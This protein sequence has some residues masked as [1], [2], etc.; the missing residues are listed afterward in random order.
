MLTRVDPGS[1]N[2]LYARLLTQGLSARSVAHVHG[3]V[4]K[5]LK[6]AVRWGRLA[7]NPADAADPPRAAGKHAAMV[8]WDATET[9]QFSRCHEEDRLYAAWLMLATT[10]GTSRGGAG[11]ALVGPGP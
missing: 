5:L 3:I 4:H 7:R 6:D 2:G 9:A 8:T 11:V 1:S 10:G